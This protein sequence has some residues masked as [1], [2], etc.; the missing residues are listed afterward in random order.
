MVAGTL[1]MVAPAR[2][3]LGSSAALTD[4][5]SMSKSTPSGLL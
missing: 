1:A 3:A 2:A 5:I 4:Q